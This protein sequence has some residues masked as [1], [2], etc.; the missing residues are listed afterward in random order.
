MNSARHAARY[1]GRYMA[2]PALVEHKIK[3]YDGV[4]VTFVEDLAS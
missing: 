3:E 4:M 2:R 1:I